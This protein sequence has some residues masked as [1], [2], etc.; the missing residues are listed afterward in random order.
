MEVSADE[1]VVAH[2]QSAEGLHD[3]ECPRDAAP[4]ETMR[5]FAGYDLAG[6]ADIAVARFEE[7]GD[8]RK[9]CCLAGA[10]RSDQRR[11]ASLLGRERRSIDRQQAA[12]A[13]RDAV[14]DEKRIS[15]GLAS[16]MEG[17]GGAP[18]RLNH[19]RICATAAD[20]AARCE[21]DDQYKHRAVQNKIEP[22]HVSSHQLRTLRPTT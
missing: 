18:R 8:D 7:S 10:I 5:R 14:D 13:A 3:L 17:T 16:V 1:D 12:E 15:H 9:E 11:D 22:G 2:G 4:R 21:P 20:Q 19:R 6:I